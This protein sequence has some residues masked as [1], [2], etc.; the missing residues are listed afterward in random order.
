MN[1]LQHYNRT[2][3]LLYLIK[4]QSYRLLTLT[5]KRITSLIAFCSLIAISNLTIAAT[6]TGLTGDDQVKGPFPIGFN[7]KFYQQEFKDFYASTNGLLQFTNPSTAYSN[8]CLPSSLNNTL[9]V[10]WDDLR[11]NVT[12]QPNGT[13]YY[14]TI[15]E[16]PD[17]QLIVQW[18]NQYFYGSNLPMGTFQA[19]LFEGS[20]EIKFQ[21]RNL[22]DDRSKG[23]S[24]TIGIQGE[25]KLAQQISCNQSNA[26]SSEQAIVFTPNESL[27]G[28]TVNTKA[29]YDFIDISGLSVRPPVAA[30]R[31]TKTNLHWTWSQLAT[32]TSYEIEIQDQQGNTVLQQVVGNVGE[33]TYNTNLTNGKSYKARVR[34]SINNGGT[35]EF[36]S[37]F[38]LPITVDTGK[39]QVQ[40]DSFSR[41]NDETLKITYQAS[42]DISGLAVV[43]LQIASDEAFDTILVT[44]Q[45]SIENTSA[46]ITSIN[47]RGS[48][49]AR[50]NAV[51]QIGNISDF[52]NI[53][54]I[55]LLAP[56]IITPVT[57]SKLNQASVMVSGKGEAG[58][59]VQL[60]LN[61]QAIGS[62]L[63]VDQQNNFST[64]ITLPTEGNYQLSATIKTDSGTSEL[65]NLI[66]VEYKLPIPTAS[67]VTPTEGL[68]LVAPTQIEISAIDELAIKQVE[69]YINNSKKATLTK[70]PYQYQWDVTQLKNGDYTIK[71]NVINS[72]NK[73]VTLTRQVKVDIQQPEIPQTIYTGEI[74][75]ISPKTSYGP[76]PITFTGHAIYRTD[77]E[78]AANLPL[79]LLLTTNGFDK[80]IN[81]VTDAT[82]AFSYT[83]QPAAHDA[84]LYTAMAIHPKESKTY[85]QGNF[86]INRIKFDITGYNLTTARHLAT[87]I[88]VTATTSAGA[89][90]LHW[91]LRAED[92]PTGTL[93]KGI[94]I[95]TSATVNIAAGK[96]AP[97]IINFKADDTAP[98][99]G[100]L[101]LT[102]FATDSG[103]LER[104]KFQINYRLTPATPALTVTPTYIET[105]VQQ[106][107]SIVESVKLTN[108]GLIAAENVQIKLLDQNN[109]PAP[110]WVFIS[111]NQLGSL[112]VGETVD[113]QLTAQPDSNLADGIYKFNI[114]VT[115][116]NGNGGTIPVSVSVTQHGQGSVMFDVADIY[117][118]TL[119]E[120]GL[121]IQGVANVTIKLQ[122]EN[123]LTQQYQLKTNQQGLA[124]L[125]D[126]PPGIYRYRASATDHVDTSGMLVI[127]PNVTTNEHIF[128]EY[129]LINI[130]FN[131][132]ET[133]VQDEY[134]IELE[135]SFNTQ[136]PAPV[137]VFEPMSISLNGMQAGD[138]KT[139]ELVLTNYGL[140]QAENVKFFP[141]TSDTKFHYEF[142]AE[143]PTT[144]A[145]KTRIVI[146]YKVTALAKPAFRMASAFST[147][148]TNEDCDSYVKY[149]SE[150]HTSEC[151]NGDTS[152]GRSQGNYNKVAGKSCNT[153]SVGGSNNIGGWGSGG[154]GGGT[155]GG[156][157][158][159]W[160]GGGLVTPNPMPLTPACIPDCEDG[161]G[162]T[163]SSPVN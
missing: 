121:P 76:Q 67:F 113:L 161:C 30:S 109:N 146:P 93:P 126:I 162:G 88:K 87:P 135:A 111:S 41:L 27:T 77:A 35:W 3:F 130:E 97:L 86:A 7:F 28:Y 119:D 132:T 116:S 143:V 44:E 115:A 22:F 103:N 38:S 29:E 13:V 47:H 137:M 17:R 127:R 158:G 12:G 105:G 5:L 123:V 49:Y 120:N 89:T 21:Y 131:V 50:I 45:L 68:T 99:T 90:N 91:E 51:D 65:S 11:T 79:T 71:V 66:S 96:S 36:W 106:A 124:E 60:F 9:Y 110:N 73:I 54:S 149:F 125:N 136:V 157:S 140:V 114:I 31:Y 81:V 98:E 153:A 32:L 107:S 156:A 152:N 69:I 4:K 58:G 85:A 83:F 33:F 26:L 154:F 128:M 8:N 163:G 37:G 19:I 102:A 55:E 118:A 20:N 145:P 151:A 18:T 2:L 61:A 84:G 159:G 74:T 147:E 95:D 43:N 57:N 150:E 94:E 56:T 129:Q 144:I 78:K 101:F 148:T 133:T 108:K 16:A 80:T 6:D 139:G 122:N 42:D 112:E 82:G 92:Q 142:L 15:G 23:N 155:S 10:F 75:D 24:A 62:E 14:E 70:I 48:L 53:K 138:I 59:L 100:T 72:S 117:T 39:P 52:S 104:G 46:T 1:I 141:P 134:E 63:E 34:G 64:T 25:N 160:T 40:V